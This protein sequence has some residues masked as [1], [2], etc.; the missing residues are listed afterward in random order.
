MTH[1][2]LVAIANEIFRELEEQ[3]R[4]AERR[5]MTG[6][7]PNDELQHQES[8]DFAEH[9]HDVVGLEASGAANCSLL[10]L[11]DVFLR[12]IA[13]YQDWVARGGKLERSKPAA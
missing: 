6:C 2:E 12:Q 7:D 11:A 5:N 4:S 8:D 1:Q 13:R 9:V 3:Q 10:T